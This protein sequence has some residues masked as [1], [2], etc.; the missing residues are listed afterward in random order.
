[1]ESRFDFYRILLPGALFI[2][3]IDIVIRVIAATPGPHDWSDL[4]RV[5]SFVEDPLR[6]LVLAFGVGVI[7]Y[8]IEPGNSA[9]Q[10]YQGIPSQHLWTRMRKEG[11]T[12]SNVSMFFAA[13]D[14]FMP[15]A[16]RSR[17][18]LYGAFYR[19]GFQVVVFTLLAAGVLPFLIVTL[20]RHD[21]SGPWHLA[22]GTRLGFWL[23]GVSVAVAT[24]VVATNTG[25]KT[26]RAIGKLWVGAITMVL[27]NSAAW[28][29]FA[30]QVTEEWTQWPNSY[31]LLAGVTTL[32]SAAWFLLRLR[33]PLRPFFRH[34]RKGGGRKPDR[35][36]TAGQIALLDCAMS[37][38]GFA[39]LLALDGKVSPAQFG[40]V[41]GMLTISLIVSLV[42]K[43][44]TRLAGIYKNQNEWIDRNFD[45]IVGRQEPS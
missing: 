36:H 2:G 41:V 7:L 8:F 31:W 38:H 13:S 29:N 10:Y 21:G 3:L 16:L 1:M 26:N 17:A 25:R 15:E 27:L 5:A 24:I 23:V 34:L 6:G 28:A 33:G 32:T 20:S 14:D 30:G 35:P 19:I 39:G 44:E 42:K 9:P 4:T 43:Y 45:R 12:G 22:G 11:V 37:S 18:L 40:A